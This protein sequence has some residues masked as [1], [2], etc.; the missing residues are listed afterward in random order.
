MLR[1]ILASFMIFLAGPGLYYI[2]GY[3]GKEQNWTLLFTLVGVF[4]IINGIVWFTGKSNGMKPLFLYIW[5]LVFFAMAA[6]MGLA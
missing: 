2:S 6:L 5:A 3:S 4:G 1:T